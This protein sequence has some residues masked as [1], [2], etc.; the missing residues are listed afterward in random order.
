MT[1][2]ENLARITEEV[3][4]QMRRFG[5]ILPETSQKLLEAQ[6]GISNFGFK[7]Q[8][9]TNIMGNLADAVGD[10]TR[11][12]YRGE[13]GAA[14]FNSSISRMADAAQGVAVALSLLVPG[15]AIVKGVVAG[16]TFMTTQF[17]KQGAA[18][19][20]TANTQADMMY[21][22]FSQLAESG[23]VGADGIQGLFE[24]IQ[25]LGLNVTK[26][27]SFLALAGQNADQLALMGGTV[28]KGR[29]NFAD[30]G[31]SVA[32]YE[33]GLR[34][35]GLNEDQQAE[36][37]LGFAKIQN[38]LALGQIKD[39]KQLGDSAYKYIQ[40][41]DALTK[42]T[43]ISRKQQED[44]LDEA[45]RNQR[46]AATIDELI[47][48]GKTDEAKQL[49]TGLMAAR[50][51]GK[52]MGD[53]YADIASGMVTT[54]AARK[55][56]ITS[57]GELLRQVEDTKRGMFKEAPELFDQSMQRVFKATG[58]FGEKLRGSAKAGVFEDFAL[59]YSTSMKSLTIA[60]NNFAETMAKARQQTQDQ[61]NKPDAALGTQ[62]ELRKAQNDTML[63]FQAFVQTGIPNLAKNT[64]VSVAT[65]FNK[66]LVDLRRKLG[67]GPIVGDISALDAR[68]PRSP[69]GTL[70]TGT[71]SAIIESNANNRPGDGVVSPSPEQR[72]PPPGGVRFPS[73]IP[74]PYNRQNPLP[75]D[76][77]GPPSVTNPPPPPAEPPRI[78]GGPRYDPFNPPLPG[79]AHGTAGELK[80]L[81]EPKDIIAQLHKGERVLNKDENTDLTKLFNMVTGDK[82]K[83]KMLDAQTELLG[84]IGG[85]KLQKKMPD[86]QGQ[87]LKAID[88]ITSGMKT[89]VNP[90]A[91]KGFDAAYADISSGMM[92][93]GP[94]Q[95]ALID[96]QG[97][98]LKQIDSIKTN[99]MPTT[100]TTGALLGTMPS[101]EIDKEAAAQISQSFKES[102][103]DEFKSAVTNINK[104]A[105][106]MQSQGD[107][108]LQQQ[109]VGL[110]E[111]MRRSMQATAKASERLAQVASN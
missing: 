68:Q 32:K 98:I 96:S 104:L 27:D 87:M 47:A 110:L 30:L 86:A 95:Q 29:K 21:N 20:E 59:Q 84:M 46:F 36:A 58:E 3:N 37:A 85:N 93:T 80:S 56:L 97:Q 81:F 78:P 53:A 82:S 19:T 71:G 18:L 91:N 28:A 35:L 106:Q 63:T 100:P 2:E 88:N 92:N 75:V 64:M 101:L 90:G 70:G 107:Q 99:A 22:A 11:A 39:F 65:E 76:I 77:V 23:A 15:G 25:K 62:A 74:N 111:E 44:A 9:A 79:R 40:E 14:V 24:D 52:D 94:A 33:V 60:N 34:K 103:G 66:L 109:M 42:V 10:Y 54:E 67:S 41:Q 48:Q 6:T 57:Q 38:R 8:I 83:N 13:K 73:P 105:G 50:A 69:G 26:L 4:E 17:L 55:G 49:Q 7:V 61:I 108:G 5:Y 43:G 102:M 12:M 31:T 89:K 72:N 1:P 51:A 45:M 16:L